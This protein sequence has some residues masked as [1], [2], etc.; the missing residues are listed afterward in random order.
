VPRAT[1]SQARAPNFQVV[2]PWDIRASG[3]QDW[4]PDDERLARTNH[5][6]NWHV[7]TADTAA[8]D[9]LTNDF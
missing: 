5:G 9:M 6:A 3:L 4:E 7:V 2:R 8:V 1:G